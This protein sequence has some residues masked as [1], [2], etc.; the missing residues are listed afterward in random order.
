MVIS[1][2]D[3]VDPQH[4]DVEA[5]VQVRSRGICARKPCIEVFRHVC[6]L[7]TP[8]DRVCHLTLLDGEHPLAV[9]DVGDIVALVYESWV[10]S[11]YL[12]VGGGVDSE[13]N[14]GLRDG[15]TE[16]DE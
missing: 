14:G 9:G 3:E 15:G 1:S 6:T 11:S 5:A 12:G 4:L 7:A 2:T 13:D 16:R 8:L 10:A